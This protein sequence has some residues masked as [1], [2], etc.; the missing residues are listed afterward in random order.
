MLTLSFRMTPPS[1]PEQPQTVKMAP[2][3]IQTTTTT[4]I[5]IPIG[6]VMNQ[7]RTNPNQAVVIDEKTGLVALVTKTVEKKVLE[8]SVLL[9][10]TVA[11]VS[12]YS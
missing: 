3:E 9:N 10:T 7:I 11:G 1:S 5:P 12:V 8:Q 4:G 6:P 2:L